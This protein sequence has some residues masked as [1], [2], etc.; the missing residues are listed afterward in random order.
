MCGLFEPKVVDTQ[1]RVELPEYLENYEQQSVNR[2]LEMSDIGRAIAGFSRDPNTGEIVSPEYQRYGGD[3]I[4]PFTS[5]QLSAFDATR[6]T[7]GFG[8]QPARGSQALRDAYRM[9]DSGSDSWTQTGGQNFAPGQVNPGQIRSGTYG[10][11]GGNAYQNR[12]DLGTYNDIT[13][14][15]FT[16]QGV[17]NSYMN[18]YM[19]QVA[20]GVLR[21]L[22]EREAMQENSD[23]AQLAK[24]NGLGG[25]RAAVLAGQRARGFDDTR[26][27]A[28]SQLYGNAYNTAGQVFGQDQ[29][30][31]LQAG[32]SNQQADLT[33]QGMG[34]QYGLAAYDANRNQFNVDAQ[35]GFD[36]AKQNQ[37]LG[38]NAQQ[39]NNTMGLDAFN[40]NRQQFN[41]DQ[42]RQLDSAN[43]LGS[44]GQT[45]Q[46]MA[47]G[48]INAMYNQGQ[49]LQGQGQQG[50][51]LA[52]NDFLNQ[53]QF[54]Y[55]QYGMLQSTFTGQP[56]QNAYGNTQQQLGPSTGSQ[57]AGAAATGIGLYGM[58]V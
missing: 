13:T 15:R 31:A 6:E 49:I 8:G 42:G 12:G 32:Q 3:R 44:L 56:N 37:L 34:E 21:D 11:A 48:N 1:A 54:P 17:A 25:T 4:Q 7:T 40:A 14:Q 51:N 28:L 19:D 27:D 46:N 57:L 47:F 18:P 24:M 10:D 29:I 26:T 5:D 35:R 30:R 22:D 41:T 52:Y 39:F 38:L 20:T 16:D 55:Q 53:Q 45:E 9:I 23:N 43:M 58:F 2:I 36:A 33:A 50:L